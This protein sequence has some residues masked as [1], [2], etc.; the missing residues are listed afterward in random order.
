M[1][2]ADSVECK[3]QA[4]CFPAAYSNMIFAF[5]S[6]IKVKFGDSSSRLFFF[7]LVLSNSDEAA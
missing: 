3:D 2:L 7:D 4:S 1:L 5:C 6:L